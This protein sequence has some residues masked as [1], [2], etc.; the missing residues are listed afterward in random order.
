MLPRQLR[1]AFGRRFGEDVSVM[2]ARRRVR[3]GCH[4]AG[5]CQRHHRKRPN[6]CP[7]IVF[8]PLPD[9]VYN[10]NVAAEALAAGACATIT[11]QT[12]ACCHGRTRGGGRLGCSVRSNRAA[13]LASLSL[14]LAL[15]GCAA[16]ARFR[17]Q[18]FLV[19]KPLRLFG[20]KLGYTY[21]QSRRCASRSGR[22]RQTISSTPMAPARGTSRRRRRRRLAAA[23]GAAAHQM[24]LRCLA[25][26]SQSA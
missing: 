11:P 5:A 10:C 8:L 2:P 17:H 26:A 18:R 15:C 22:L 12:G 13:W 16:V 19:W 21:A 4:I 6:A 1:F 24:Q 14:P 23:T 7:L 3:D 20:N 9:S 25:V